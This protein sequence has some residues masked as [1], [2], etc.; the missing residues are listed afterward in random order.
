MLF[1][2]CLK[3]AEK[4]RKK[5]PP[6]VPVQSPKTSSSPVSPP[7]AGVVAGKLSDTAVTPVFIPRRN[8]TLSYYCHN[9]IITISTV[10]KLEFYNIV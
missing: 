6:P 4:V 8:C 1:I 9:V 10:K 2:F 5:Q 3:S 7:L